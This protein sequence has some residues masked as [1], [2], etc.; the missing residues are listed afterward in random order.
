[1]GATLLARQQR[2]FLNIISI[3]S[4]AVTQKTPELRNFGKNQDLFFLF[5]DIL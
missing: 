3:I 5:G 1:L 4:F 2:V